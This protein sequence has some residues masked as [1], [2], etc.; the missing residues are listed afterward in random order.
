M[1][2]FRNLFVI[3]L[4]AIL[5]SGCSPLEKMS[6]N[7]NLVTY[8]ITP[9]VLETHAGIVAAQVKATYPEKYFDKKTTLKITPVLT[10]TGGET[11]FDELLYTQGEDVQGNNKPIARTGG[12][13]SWSGD[14]AYKPEMKVSEFLLRIDASRKDKTLAFAPIKLADGVIATSTLFEYHPMP[15]SLKDSYQ[16]IVPEQK[17]A[18]ILY[19]INRSDIKTTELKAD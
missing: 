8:E 17:I 12:T 13:A 6:K 19:S 7:A 3:L 18:D 10:Y 16:R 9:K 2:N 4:A 14:V 11:V 5:V 15:L 1:K